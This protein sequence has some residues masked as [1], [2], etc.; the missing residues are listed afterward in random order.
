MAL[1]IDDTLDMFSIASQ[2]SVSSVV[3]YIAAQLNVR[4]KV[5]EVPCNGRTIKLNEMQFIS[6]VSLAQKNIGG[7]SHYDDDSQHFMVDINVLKYELM[8]EK[9]HLMQ[10]TDG[11]PSSHVFIVEDMSNTYNQ[12]FA[13][14]DLQQICNQCNGSCVNATILWVLLTNLQAPLTICQNVAKKLPVGWTEGGITSERIEELMAVAQDSQQGSTGSDRGKRKKKVAGVLDS[15]LKTKE[16]ANKCVVY[17]Q[18]TSKIGNEYHAH[19]AMMMKIDVAAI[20][21][22]DCGLRR[23]GVLSLKFQEEILKT[24]SF[25]FIGFGSGVA[26]FKMPHHEKEVVLELNALRLIDGDDDLMCRETWESQLKALAS[27]FFQTMTC[28]NFQFD[29]FNLYIVKPNRSES[30]KSISSPRKR[31]HRETKESGKRKKVPDVHEAIPGFTE[32]MEDLN[33]AIAGLTDYHFPLPD[34]DTNIAYNPSSPYINKQ[35]PVRT[36][37]SSMFGISVSNQDI[38]DI[39]NLIAP[40][41]SNTHAVG[42]RIECSVKDE[43]K[44]LDE[45]YAVS[46]LKD[47]QPTSKI[48][49]HTWANYSTYIF[50]AV[51]NHDFATPKEFAALLTYA[52]GGCDIATNPALNIIIKH[53]FKNSAIRVLV[54]AS[55]GFDVDLSVLEFK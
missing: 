53:H 31:K 41:N 55:L 9:I 16:N 23:F 20:L 42:V 24:K 5:V 50:N 46:F 6:W 44:L 8:R 1:N 37:D 2:T 19:V 10:F 33:A 22:R 25:Y 38:L 47:M 48:D 26:K 43:A 12:R 27:N 52:L 28:V 39:T 15:F 30:P 11:A 54:M 35:N 51:L 17:D 21:F 7:I 13:I 40:K 49:S 4:S 34:Y 32:E 3:N 29:V 18:I 45:G 14:V 36:D